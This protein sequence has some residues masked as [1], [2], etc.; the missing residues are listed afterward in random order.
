MQTVRRGG[1]VFTGGAGPGSAPTHR[2]RRQAHVYRQGGRDAPSNRQRRGGRRAGSGPGGS[3]NCLP[4]EIRGG[5]HRGERGCGLGSRSSGSLGALSARGPAAPQPRG[6]PA[7]LWGRDGVTT[8]VPTCGPLPTFSGSP[9]RVLPTEPSL[10]RPPLPQP[11]PQLT[12]GHSAKL[13]GEPSLCPAIQAA[14]PG[15]LHPYGP[16][17]PRITITGV[18]TPSPLPE[19]HP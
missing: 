12:S 16:S 1:A 10:L 3:A 6:Y 9:V 4:R 7:G 5:G 18:S 15:P 8:W 13:L 11:R 19:D 2:R 14:C 17:G